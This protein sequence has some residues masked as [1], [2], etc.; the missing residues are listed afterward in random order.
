MVIVDSAYTSDGILTPAAGFHTALTDA[1]RAAG[2]LVV[3]DEVQAG[4][5]RTGD[6]LWSYVATGLVPDVVALGKPMG[7]GYPVAAVV[8]RREHV[9][10]LGAEG[11]F[12]STFAG[13]PVAAVAA[14]AVLDVVEDLDLVAH[15]AAMGELLRTRL[16]EHTADCAAVRDVRGRGL[17]VGVDL[18]GESAATVRD[19]VDRVREAGVLIGTTGRRSD[20]L[21]IRPPLVIDAGQVERVADVVG[22]ALRRGPG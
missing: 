20:V 21:K 14:L 2:A 13:S 5:G 17:L 6:H 11:E 15:A 4:Y 18:E 22:A 16:R 10:A 8:T 1:A 3:A 7:N 9:D 19:V 12:F